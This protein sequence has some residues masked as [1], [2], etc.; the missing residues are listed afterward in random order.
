MA[1]E[2]DDFTPEQ[3]RL[4]RLK[5]AMGQFARY[6]YPWNDEI[7]EVIQ[8]LTNVD[9]DLHNGMSSECIDESLRRVQDALDA[10]RKS[11]AA[12]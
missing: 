7:V 8:L 2:N 11:I 6:S 5:D 3:L 12:E 10:L 4:F 1:D 9:D